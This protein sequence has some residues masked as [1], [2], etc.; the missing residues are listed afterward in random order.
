MKNKLKK[1]AVL[2]SLAFVLTGFFVPVYHVS[3]QAQSIKYTL[4]TPLPCDKDTA[5]ADCKDGVLST[6]NA[7]NSKGTEAF[8]RYLNIL[9]R[10]FI[11]LCAVLAVIMIVIGGI[12]YMTSELISSKEAGKD[13]IREALL[14]LLLALGAYTLLNTIN[15]DLLRTN[16]DIAGATLDVEIRDID[17]GPENLDPGVQYK[18]IGRGDLTSLGIQCN[19]G[20][21]AAMPAIA[22]SFI[23]HSSY[24][25]NRR[26]TVSGGIAYIDCSS[27]VSQVYTCAGLPNPGGTT[28]GIF[29]HSEQVTSKSADGT[30]IN[31]IPLKVGDL[32]G[33]PDPD[34]MGGKPGHVVM[35]I[36]NGQII[37]TL[38]A[39]K[40]VGVR[41]LKA[42][43][44]RI[45]NIKRL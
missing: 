40:G 13:R 41:P 35:Y 22:Q 3:A 20:G 19:G 16:V 45:T 26:N 33:H 38:G 5:G 29:N 2:F 31:G 8:G 34:G 17:I 27:F 4:L 14:G 25:Q 24:D 42:Y 36:G 39:A 11:G 32:L 12:E 7:D 21:P 6:F 1:F 18:S 44:S 28:V 23:G 10:I 30:V 43:L 37:D 15:P 9:I